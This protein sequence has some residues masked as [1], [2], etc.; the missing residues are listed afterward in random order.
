MPGGHMGQFSYLLY[1][2]ALLG[3]V[4]RKPPTTW[5]PCLA[6]LLRHCESASGQRPCR[7]RPQRFKKRI[8]LKGLRTPT[9]DSNSWPKNINGM[10]FLVA[11]PY[12]SPHGRSGRWILFDS[13]TTMTIH[14]IHISFG[15]L[16]LKIH[17][18]ICGH[19]PISE[20]EGLLRQPDPFGG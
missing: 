2:Q 13:L 12:P 16:T 17:C 7:F 6:K 8:C 1:F 9:L 19:D 15:Q 10:T 14:P 11:S 4:A 20:P 18:E 3:E 5:M